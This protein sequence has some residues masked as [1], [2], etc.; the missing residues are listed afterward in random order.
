MTDPL[1]QAMLLTELQTA[2][3]IPTLETR[4]PPAPI[5]T[6]LGFTANTGWQVLSYKAL[7]VGGWVSLVL[8]MKYV[9][10]TA[11]PANLD[12]NLITN[13]PECLTSAPT[14]YR[15]PESNAITTVA[16]NVTTGLP[17]VGTWAGAG[18]TIESCPTGQGVNPNNEFVFSVTFYKGGA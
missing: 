18:P 12:T 11:Y 10:T 5:T 1:Q 7:A 16:F 2:A 6:G 4:T 13:V 3:A 17:F 15:T 9:G 8:D 14:D